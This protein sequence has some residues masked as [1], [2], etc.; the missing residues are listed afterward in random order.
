M[1]RSLGYMENGA[2]GGAVTTNTFNASF[3]SPTC[4][5]SECMMWRWADLIRRKKVETESGNEGEDDPIPARPSHVPETWEFFPCDGDPAGWVEPEAEA[6]LRRRG[7]CGLAGHPFP[8]MA[9]TVG[10]AL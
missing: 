6:Q 4:I 1:T 7:Y 10:G 5:G 3:E 9:V 2:G 8:M